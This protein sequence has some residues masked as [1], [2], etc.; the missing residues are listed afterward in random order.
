MYHDCPLH[1]EGSQLQLACRAYG[2]VGQLFASP[3]RCEGSCS[4][5]AGHAVWVSSLL[6]TAKL[7]SASTA[8]CVSTAEAAQRCCHIQQRSLMRSSVTADV[9]AALEFD[10]SKCCSMLQL[11]HLFTWRHPKSQNP[12]QSAPLHRSLRRRP[13]RGHGLRAACH[14]LKFHRWT[15]SEAPQSLFAVPHPHPTGLQ[16]EG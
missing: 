14:S 1:F 3:L 11:H 10:M 12:R 2:V 4:S 16:E 9:T 15:Q 8:G 7:S 6:H 5:L 13:R